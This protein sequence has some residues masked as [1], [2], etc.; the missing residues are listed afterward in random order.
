MAEKANKQEL[1]LD[2]IRRLKNKYIVEGY[3]IEFYRNFSDDDN[4]SV[5]LMTL[6]GNRFIP[7]YV[8]IT[9]AWLMKFLKD[10]YNPIVYN[11]GNEMFPTGGKSAPPDGMALIPDRAKQGVTKD[12]FDLTRKFKGF[13]DLGRYTE[14]LLREGHAHG[15]VSDFYRKIAEQL[16]QK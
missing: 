4:D 8:V 5:K 12:P 7:E 3:K 1:L 10:L 14:K 11:Y 9:E 6:H 15:V 13:D 2:C 16:R